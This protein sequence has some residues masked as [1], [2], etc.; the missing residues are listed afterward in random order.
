MIKVIDINCHFLSTKLPMANLL[1]KMTIFVNFFEKNCQVFGN[2]LTVK[3]QFS[4]LSDV[5]YKG[6]KKPDKH[7]HGEVVYKYLHQRHYSW[8]SFEA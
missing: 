5:N 3:W 7:P 6:K 8:S 4:G 2:F 1:R